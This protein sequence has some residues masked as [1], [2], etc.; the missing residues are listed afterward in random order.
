[1]DS[2]VKE[3]SQYLAGNSGLPKFYMHPDQAEF[4]CRALLSCHFQ[5]ARMRKNLELFAVDL[6]GVDVPAKTLVAYALSRT[7]EWIAALQSPN[8]DAT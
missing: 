5:M 6:G 7:N 4:L 3:A 2:A 8:G 1:M